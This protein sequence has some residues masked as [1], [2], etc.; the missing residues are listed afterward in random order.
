MFLRIGFN[1]TRSTS[2]CYKPK[3][4]CIHHT[5][6]HNTKMNLAQWNG[7]SERGGDEGLA[8]WLKQFSDSIWVR[9][10]GAR[11]FLIVMS[12]DVPD[13]Y[14]PRMDGSAER[15]V[16]VMRCEL[17]WT[18]STVTR[19]AASSG[20]WLDGVRRQRCGCDVSTTTRGVAGL[21]RVLNAV[22]VQNVSSFCNRDR[23][24]QT[25]GCVCLHVRG[26]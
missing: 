11:T 12:I 5:V 15:D 10:C 25:I 1:P 6:I 3:H 14:S 21:W 24:M 18:Y 13:T 26:Q 17:M 20:E 16:R 23:V 19:P 22:V 7:P 9:R 4:S 2:P 8:P